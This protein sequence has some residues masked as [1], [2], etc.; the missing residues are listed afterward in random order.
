MGEGD[1]T[2]LARA[3]AFLPRR[4]R[5]PPRS[6]KRGDTPAGAGRV[7]A[8]WAKSGAS[9]ATLPD[10]MSTCQLAA[11]SK[12]SSLAAD[13]GESERRA[14]KM[15]FLRVAISCN[16]TSTCVNAIF[17]QVQIEPPKNSALLRSFRRLPFMTDYSAARPKS[18]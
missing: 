17:G 11:F 3:S 9:Q 7:Y 13:Y 18:P 16:V 4:G 12:P 2:L 1:P 14:F 6:G 15:I 10:Y 8:P 5:A